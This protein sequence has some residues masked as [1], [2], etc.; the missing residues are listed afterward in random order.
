MPQ[1]E[2]WCVIIVIILAG[3]VSST[4]NG[5]GLGTR[6]PKGVLYYPNW[7]GLTDRREAGTLEPI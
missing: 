5:V 6:Y 2:Q 7:V 4:E 1:S 3:F